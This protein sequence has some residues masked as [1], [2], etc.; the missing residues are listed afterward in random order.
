MRPSLNHVAIDAGSDHRI[1]EGWVMVI[2]RG[3]VYIGRVQVTTVWIDFSGG[4]ILDARKPIRVGDEAIII[5]REPRQRL[6][7]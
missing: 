7:Y 4:K 3:P 5:V 1:R 6:R 2:H